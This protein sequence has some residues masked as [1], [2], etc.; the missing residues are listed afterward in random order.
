M[1]L[2]RQLLLLLLIAT[3]LRSPGQGAESTAATLLR[4]RQ[5]FHT[6]LLSQKTEKTRVEIAPRKIFSTIHQRQS[7][8]C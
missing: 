3:G 1:K 4:A 6:K 2:F 5:N 7:A 8:V